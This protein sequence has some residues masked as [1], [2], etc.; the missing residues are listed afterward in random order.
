MNA[1]STALVTGGTGF[2]GRSLVEGLLARGYTVRAIG[3]RPVLRWR[4]CP[5]IEHIR[6][7]ISEPGVLE[8][9][10]ENLDLVFHLAAATSGTPEF[11]QRVTVGSTERIL[12]LAAPRESRVV[13][14]SSASVYDSGSMA[15]GGIVDEDFSLERK[16]LARGL[17]A[18]AKTESELHAHQYLNHPKVKLTIVRPGLVYGPRTRNVLNGVTLMVRSKLLITTGTPAKLLPLI[19]IDDLVECLIQIAVNEAAIGRIYNIAHPEMP[20]TL[21][22]LETYRALSGDRRLM[23]NIPLRKLIP[24]IAVLDRLSALL[25]RKSYY[26]YSMSRLVGSSIFSSDKIRRELRFEP[27]VSFHEGLAKVCSN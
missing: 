27:R 3:R 12:A 26:A 6:A 16:P 2:V 7:D 10:I 24:I 17:Y 11:Y 8:Q 20:T 23:V 25:G 19:Y 9:A 18:R 15:N 14:V 13:I 1:R 22:F 21:Q 4:T 5:G